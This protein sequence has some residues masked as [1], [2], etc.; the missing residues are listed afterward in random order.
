M[1]TAKKQMAEEKLDCRGMACPNPV[2]KTKEIVD[3]G[4]VETLN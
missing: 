1:R 3:R 2:L 4:N